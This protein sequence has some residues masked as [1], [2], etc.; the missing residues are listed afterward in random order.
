[1]VADGADLGR[2]AEVDRDEVVHRRFVLV[3][4]FRAAEAAHDRTQAGEA[5]HRAGAPR[6]HQE[7]VHL[8]QPE[9]R[10]VQEQVDRLALVEALLAANGKG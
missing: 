8:E 2:D 5:L 6:A 7:P 9:R 4:T 3:V 10:G 1:M